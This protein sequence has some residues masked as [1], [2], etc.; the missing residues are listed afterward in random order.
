M[1]TGQVTK[2]EG[3]ETGANKYTHPSITASGTTSVATPGFGSTF[4]ALDSVTVNSNGHV[5]AFNTKTVTVPSSTA[6]TTANGLMTTAQVTKLNGIAEN[7]N[8]Y[9]HP[10]ITATSTSTTAAPGYGGTFTAIDSVT[11]NSN[12]HVTAFNTKTV[13]LPASDNTDTYPSGISVS[14]TSGSN[15]PTITITRAGTTTTSISGNI[16][17]AT[18][19]VN[20]VVSTTAQ[21]FAGDKTFNGSIVVG[22]HAKLTFSTSG[23]DNILTVSFI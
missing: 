4:T 21:T 1:T 16:P 11:V 15:A 22:G 14:S 7:A 23:S 8:N 9:T 6:T 13:T 20:G 17:L 5:T 10:S 19:S 12:G 2:L 18:A 3:I